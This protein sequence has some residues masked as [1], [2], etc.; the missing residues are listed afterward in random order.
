VTK[1]IHVEEGKKSK[2][3]DRKKFP[4]K[5]PRTDLAG[6]VMI[7]ICLSHLHFSGTHFQ[8]RMETVGGAL[9]TPHY[10]TA[11]KYLPY[12]KFSLKGEIEQGM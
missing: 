12:P 9:K 8:G 6:D 7:A 5:N 11:L 10:K 3:Y 1:E 4:N 2:K